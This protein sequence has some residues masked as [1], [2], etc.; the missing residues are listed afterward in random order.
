MRRLTRT[1]ARRVALAAQGFTRPRPPGPVTARHLAAVV[2]RL[3][4]FQIDSVNVLARAHH[5]PLYSRAGPYDPDLL[6][7]AY[8]RAPRRLVEYWAHEAALLDVRLW[9]AFAFRREQPDRMW[10]GIARVGAEQPDL[11]RRVLADVRA[12]GPV[13]ARQVEHEA[14][15]DRDHWGWNW[16]DAKHALEYLFYTGQVTSAGRTPQFERLYDLTERVLPAEVLAAPALSPDQCYRVL[17]EHAASAHGVATRQCLADYFRLRPGPTAAAVEDLADE[18]VLVPATV[19]G[20]DRPAWLHRDAVLPRAVRARALLSP[21]DPLVFER[22]RTERLFDFRYRLEIYVPRERRVHG[23]YVLP[24][25]LGDR[26][27][28]RVDLAAD[29]AAGVLRVHGAF[30]EPSAP[31]HTAAELAAE[32]WLMAGW[33]G[34]E[35][36]AVADHGDLATA[37]AAEVP[38]RWSGHLD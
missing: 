31:P 11:V 5:L 17:V 36:V 12:A 32:L 21:F 10:G 23:Y 8:G 35:D 22:T 2:G 25:L 6:H 15:T 9:P 16:S 24:F 28:A 3:G 26:L 34:L 20:W 14:P 37:L 29:R 30:G 19:Q 13:T 7:R 1:Q 38:R 18:G 33:L 27:V 4:L